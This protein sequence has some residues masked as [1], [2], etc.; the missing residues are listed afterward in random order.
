MKLLRSIYWWRVLGALICLGSLALWVLA[1][2]YAIAWMYLSASPRP[3]S[4]RFGS[5]LARSNAHEKS[6]PR[7]VAARR[8]RVW[9]HLFR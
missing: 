9:L 7:H 1:I 6:E 5:A 2:R 4:T 8:P 3:S